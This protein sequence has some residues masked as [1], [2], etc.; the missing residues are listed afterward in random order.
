MELP[1]H[2]I[3]LD[4]TKTQREPIALA[5][6]QNAF[7]AACNQYHT[8]RRGYGF[9]DERLAQ[10][11]E[12]R[13]RIGWGNRLQRGSSGFYVPV[14]ISAGG[15]IGEAVDH[16]VATKLIRKMRD[17]HDNRPEDVQDV[18]RRFTEGLTGLDPE[19]M[20][21]ATAESVISIRMLKDELRR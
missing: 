2:Q 5:A 1:R 17:R 4:K 9:L 21:K 14:V 16:I 15:S 20:K 10:V 6:L 3:V 13:F 8:K 18:E 11:L 12:R 7:D 19:W